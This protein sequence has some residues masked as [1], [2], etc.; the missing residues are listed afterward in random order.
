MGIFVMVVSVFVVFVVVVFF[1]VV[2]VVALFFLNKYCL[3]PEVTGGGGEK[4]GGGLNV[5]R[6]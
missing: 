4:R 3:Q 2:F 6:T 1:V 5:I